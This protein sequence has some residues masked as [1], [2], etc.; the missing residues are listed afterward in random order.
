MS[1][2]LETVMEV[3]V[4]V[5]VLSIAVIGWC[6]LA[7]LLWDGFLAGWWFTITGNRRRCRKAWEA[8]VERLDRCM[9]IIP[10]AL[11]SEVA[12]GSPND[13]YGE[14]K[15]PINVPDV[16]VAT[17]YLYGD[18]ALGYDVIG[19]FEGTL[20]S[21]ICICREHSR[22]RGGKYPTVRINKV[23]MNKV[24]SI[25][26]DGTSVKEYNMEENNYDRGGSDALPGTT[27][28]AYLTHGERLSHS[29]GKH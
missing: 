4:H 7:R 1:S 12:D 3:S 11:V 9:G 18:D 26:S 17:G 27:P 5:A 13:G 16:Y 10:A 22:H 23:S 20:D 28:N 2:T 8:T 15:T 29:L 25:D 21:V 14:N 6:F 24:N 19:V